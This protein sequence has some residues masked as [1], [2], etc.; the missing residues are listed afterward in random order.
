[1]NSRRQARFWAIQILY[2]RSLNAEESLSNA[3]DDFWHGQDEVDPNTKGFCESL[4]R[5][6][7]EKLPALDKQIAQFATNWDVDRI[8][9]IDLA[10]LRLALFEMH[11]R[12]DIPPVAS[13]NEALELAK[14]FS[15]EETVKF[16]NGILDRALKDLKRPLRTSVDKG[17]G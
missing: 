8:G 17:E 15:T 6:A 11:H 14:M 5:G 1:M 10:L 7:L 4:V 13:V 16:V 9:K 2:Q 12:E 3:L